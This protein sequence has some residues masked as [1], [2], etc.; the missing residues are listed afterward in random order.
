MTLVG[1]SP[2]LL[3][4]PDS[5]VYA[6]E[7]KNLGAE[8]SEYLSGI[9]KTKPEYFEIVP[10]SNA[11]KKTKSSADDTHEIEANISPK[12]LNSIEEKLKERG[13]TFLEE[14]FSEEDTAII[15]KQLKDRGFKFDSAPDNTNRTKGYITEEDLDLIAKALKERGVKLDD[16]NQTGAG[17]GRTYAGS[18]L[19]HNIKTN[20]LYL[21]QIKAID[22]KPEIVQIPAALH[23][24]EPEDIQL[25]IKNAEERRTKGLLDLITV[26]TR[27]ANKAITTGKRRK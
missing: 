7:S 24:Q 4:D 1:G 26:H 21:I 15:V 10:L 18:P 27:M 19:Y 14:H 9:S 2:P 17:H 8:F 13:L 11:R 20:M 6:F 22:A 16:C 3:F 25:K 12:D 5:G 23:G